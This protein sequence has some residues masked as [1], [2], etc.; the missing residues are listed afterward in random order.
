MS[1]TDNRSV[2]RT[3][4]DSD[5]LLA[6]FLARP[7][8]RR[9]L[10]KLC[11]ST[12]VAL[13]A[14]GL[15]KPGLV[16]HLDTRA[17]EA[18]GPAKRVDTIHFALGP[19]PGLEDLT[20][21]ASGGERYALQ[22]HTAESRARLAR[23]GGLWRKLDTAALTHFVAGVKVPT[24]RGVLLSVEGRRGDVDVLVAQ[25]WHAPRAATARLA[26]VIHQTTGSY[27]SALGSSL[28][29]IRLGLGSP[30][31]SFSPED[32][33]D[34]D[35]IVD[36]I[37]TAVAF[38]MCHPSVSTIDPTGA[39]AT[40]MLLGATPEVESL[41]SYIDAMLNV[42]GE[43]WATRQTVTDA[44]GSATQF[45][46]GGTTTTLQTIVLN[47]TDQTFVQNAQGAL[48]AGVLG[49]RDTASLGAVI[50]E[51]LEQ[52]KTS[53]TW[54]QTEGLAPATLPQA[55]LQDAPT[56]NLTHRGTRFG[57]KVTVQGPLQNSQVT[58]RV[59]NNFV[60][61]VD[62]YVQYL[63]AR[64][65]NLSLNPSATYPD[66]KYA[67]HLSL[68][69]QVFTVLGIPIWDSNHVDVTLNLPPQA[70]TAR[71][72]MCGLGS[73]LLSG[74]WRQ[75]FPA[76]AYPDRIAP[77]DE[78][79]GAALITGILT[80]GVNVFALAT[81]IQITTAWSAMKPIIQG[82]SVLLITDVS[83][84]IL[85]STT[86]A[87]TIA[88]Q[89]GGAV[90]AGAATYAQLSANKLDAANIWNAILGVA[91]VLPKLFFSPAATPILIRLAA[92]LV[93]DEALE[94]AL[95]AVP[96]LG[97][98]MAAIALVG[99]IATLAEISLETALSPWVIENEVS[100]T[101]AATIEISRDPRAATFPVTATGWRLEAVI[102]GAS[103]LS[104]TTGPI[105]GGGHIQ[106]DPIAVTIPNV[107]FGGAVIQWAFVLTDAGGRQVGTGA[108]PK[109]PNNDAARPP[110]AVSFAI[111]ELPAPLTAQTRFVR[112]DATAWDA[113]AGGYAWS[114]DVSDQGTR[115]QSDL[116]EITGI[117][118][119]TLH[120]QV[121][122]VWKQGDRYY[123]R[124]APIAENGSAIRLQPGQTEGYA[125]RPFL[126]YDSFVAPGDSSNHV[127]LEPE[128]TGDGYHV[129]RL[130]FDAGANL[131][132]DPNTSWGFFP[133]PLS[134]AALH[135]GGR[136]VTVNAD[137]GRL[138][139]LAPFQVDVGVGGRP[140]LA[141]Y[142]GGPGDQPG[143]LQ[144]PIAVAI[145]NPGVLL[146]L[147]ADGNRIAAF[148]LNGDPLKFFPSGDGFRLS[149]VSTGTY[150][151]LA[152][153]GSGFIYALYYT[154]AG[155]A[156]GDYRIDVY[157]A[158]GNLLISQSPGVNVARLAVD[159]WRSIYGANFTA[160]AVE[161]S[162]TPHLDPALGV[163][164]PSISR[165]DPVTPS[166]AGSRWP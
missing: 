86:N 129:R 54:V 140:A 161:G 29:R 13:A 119:S 106:S 164:E 137:S 144:S 72:L 122:Y 52:V 79:L 26:K 159:Y 24:G 27:E 147:E 110:T 60:R 105:N 45:S 92:A 145:T 157:T 43:D 83:R 31:I 138:G 68:M 71:L 12:A 94:S 132:W 56:V 69:P 55:R 66:T 127:L 50:D 42:K 62:I 120:G 17:A 3:T 123:I 154:G 111:T 7:V 95:K 81:D 37:Q 84:I 99:D 96:I 73:D 108:S 32:I 38:A 9:W 41:G 153:D 33:A 150:L 126:L 80:I 77:T 6:E 87:L 134:A 117:T 39:A 133:A 166:V 148:D 20:F 47:Q 97:E 114:D 53:A 109:L 51:P 93:S 18:A 44:D 78:V 76:D 36:P 131:T 155:T 115:V 82:E 121:G 135:S 4:R 165:F 104:S 30:G 61:W 63:D 158:A 136:I 74:G 151:D 40:K 100:A 163:L 65:Q 1:T 67:K 15:L 21:H 90:A 125:R 75:Y 128:A 149:L 156:P 85:T 8:E 14:S 48:A 130:V 23:R 118:V 139:V 107:P 146:V 102:D 64:G 57:T 124:N 113:T 112:A 143:L 5:G 70:V 91:T 88:E 25:T 116:Q 101:Y 142:K 22:P 2:D 98:V 49:V 59:Y 141:S 162:S 89:V 58:L 160:L 152:V 46:I 16:R 10:L 35:T 28:R 34:L 11:G 103:G 19:L